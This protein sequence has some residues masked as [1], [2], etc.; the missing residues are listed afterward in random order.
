MPNRRHPSGLTP[1]LGPPIPSA[2]SGDLS[3]SETAEPVTSA[4]KSATTRATKPKRATA[5]AEQGRQRPK[6]AGPRSTT[7]RSV[8]GRESGAQHR[9]QSSPKRAADT[10]ASGD[11]TRR[12]SPPPIE[13]RDPTRF[14]ALGGGLTADDS[15]R[16]A[17][18]VDRARTND[19]KG[20]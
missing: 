11:Q 16:L 18:L 12:S 2:V 17:R 3:P 15:R 7:G 10:K 5:G 13:H 8:R 20:S 1:P 4:S 6:G 14:A 19:R 9:E